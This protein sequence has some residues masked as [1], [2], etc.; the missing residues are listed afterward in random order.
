MPACPIPWLLGEG[1]GEWLLTE[2][3]QDS[4]ASLGIAVP[5]SA[6][7]ALQPSQALRPP[8]C[9]LTMMVTHPSSQSTSALRLSHWGQGTR[10]LS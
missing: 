3:G 8:D 1:Q 7:T 5:V 2:K 9:T 6:G 10:P 4:S